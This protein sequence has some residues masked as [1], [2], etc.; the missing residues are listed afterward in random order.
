MLFGAFPIVYRIGRGWN[1]G[2][3]GLPFIGVAIGMMIALAYTLLYDNKRYVRCVENSPDGF[4]TP[5]DRLPSSILGGI[6]L[7][8]G[9]FWFAWTNYPEFPWAASVAAAIPFGFGMVCIFLS[10]MNYLIDS[11]TIYAASTLAGNGILRAMFG[12][13]FPLFTVQM[14]NGIGKSSIH[15]P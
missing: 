9:L 8:I 15:P 6:A 4:A 12:A 5:E 1:Q 13:V 2:V 7:P 10:V 11:Y 14:F 3:A